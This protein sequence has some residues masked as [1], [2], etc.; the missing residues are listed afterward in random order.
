M[1]GV[2]GV[3]LLWLNGQLP[4]GA[5][6]PGEKVLGRA[7]SPSH[8]HRAALVCFL[9]PDDRHH[10]FFWKKTVSGKQLSKSP[11]T[12]TAG[13]RNCMAGAARRFC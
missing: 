8:A 13:R 3:D 1:T 9:I 12:S 2:L 6:P 7:G 10:D 5:V 11:V 4:M